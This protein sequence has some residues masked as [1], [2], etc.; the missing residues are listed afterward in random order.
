MKTEWISVKDRPLVIK[1][2]HGWESTEDGSK[3]F[4]AAI[5]QNVGWWI[6]HCV[7]E[8]RVGL[9][10]VGDAENERAGYD[11]EDVTHWKPWTE[12]PIDKIS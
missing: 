8:D 10:V 2:E 4:I 5:P 6:H 11:L 7:A 9:C 12:P 1:T 3:E